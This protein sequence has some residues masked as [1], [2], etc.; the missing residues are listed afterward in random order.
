MKRSLIHIDSGKCDGCGQCVTACAEGAIQVIDG[1]ARLVSETYCDGLGACLAECPRGALSLEEREADP[2]D[3]QAVHEHMQ[4]AKPASHTAAPN[5]CP[6]AA[7]RNLRKP[8][9]SGCPGQAMRDMGNPATSAGPSDDE[10]ATGPALANW[11]VQ[12]A[13]VPPTAPFL[14][15]ADV[16]LTADCVPAAMGGFHERILHGRPLLLACPKLDDAGAHAQKLAA[17]LKQT[18]PRSLTVAHMEAP[19]CT[20]LVRLA[21]EAVS[22]SGISVPLED[23]TVSIEGGVLEAKA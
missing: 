1:K 14:Q 4:N 23:V 5:G 15:D 8:P 18:R 9:A 17:I 11:P 13:L 3:E 2:F 19:C 21:E 16:V 7:L 22:Q 12:L 20:G 6:G 10:P